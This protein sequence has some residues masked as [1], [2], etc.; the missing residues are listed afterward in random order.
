MNETQ[1]EALINS[2]GAEL[3]GTE[4][5][6]ENGRMVYRV[7]ITSKDK[8]VDLGLCTKVTQIIS[9]ILDLEPPV[10]GQYFLEVSS[11][12][13]ERKVSTPSQFKLSIGEMINIKTSE[14]KIKGELLCADEKSVRVKE[15]DSEREVFYADILKART[16][17]E[18]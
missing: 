11:P 7:F 12:G 4:S 10:S 6:S 14:E 16:F 9:P 13:L 15:E 2:A 8:E 1:L 18:W 5:V 17:V 3:Y